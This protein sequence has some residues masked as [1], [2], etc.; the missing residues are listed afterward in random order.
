MK[1]DRYFSNIEKISNA[2]KRA[3]NL[4]SPNNLHFYQKNSKDKRKN[5][6]C[7]FFQ[8]FLEKKLEKTQKKRFYPIYF[9]FLKRVFS[10]FLNFVTKNNF[11]VTNFFFIN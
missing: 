10:R 1:I 3:I 8:T 9:L 4:F 6:A 2:E 5:L 11:F 7:V